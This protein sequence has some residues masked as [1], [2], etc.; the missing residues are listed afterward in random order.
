MKAT[1]KKHSPETNRK[2]TGE[3]YRGCLVIHAAKSAELYRRV[4]GCWYGIVLGADPASRR[5]VRFSRN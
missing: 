4:E 1:L 2:N 5:N 3:A